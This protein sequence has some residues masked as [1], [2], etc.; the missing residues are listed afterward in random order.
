MANTISYKG[1]V[2]TLDEDPKIA[3][4]NYCRR[5]VPFDCSKTHMH[6]IQY[7]DDNPLRDTIESCP[8]CHG[9]EQRIY[10]S[11]KE[12]VVCIPKTLQ[13]RFKKKA[14][15]KFGPK[16]GYLSKVGEE[17]FRLWLSDGK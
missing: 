10:R 1:R 16:K 12:L 6:H 7:H 4:C 13:R 9:I 3:V 14:Y 15:K 8:T 17:A 11:S 5:V 2:V